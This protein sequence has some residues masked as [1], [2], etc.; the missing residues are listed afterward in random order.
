MVVEQ[1]GR[2]SEADGGPGTRALGSLAPV[3]GW[4][5]LKIRGAPRRKLSPIR[6]A[7]AK[8]EIVET[9]KGEGLKDRWP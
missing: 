3:T 7:G 4:L 1:R 9:Q 2:L 8:P 5:R 6:S